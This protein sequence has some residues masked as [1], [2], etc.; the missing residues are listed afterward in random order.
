MQTQVVGN[1]GYEFEGDWLTGKFVYSPLDN[2]DIV[3]IYFAADNVW[4]TD[5]EILMWGGGAGDFMVHYA[6]GVEFTL[7]GKYSIYVN[8]HDVS[9]FLESCHTFIEQ[10]GI[11]IADVRAK[12]TENAILSL[13]A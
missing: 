8:Q 4:V 11:V 1:F 6:R 13:L 5:I 12:Q 9:T 3:E 10:L 2:I 7:Y